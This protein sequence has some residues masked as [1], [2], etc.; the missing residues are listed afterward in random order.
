[1]KRFSR[2]VVL[3]FLMTGLLMPM[4][5]AFADSPNILGEHTLLFG[6]TLYCIGRAYG[7][8][9]WAIAT[10]N[11]IAV[12]DANMVKSGVK[13]QIPDVPA[14]IPAGPTCARQF[15]DASPPQ[16]TDCTCQT[17]HMIVTGDTLTKISAQ[18]SANMWEIA[19]CNNILNMNY[20][21]IADVLCI[22]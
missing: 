17:T 3:A 21:R 20:I 11:G 18:Y 2:I 16:D 5:S 19:R 10:H 22:P 14:T 6:E 8:D 4:R 15:S 12:A 7:V 9:P 1:M 13:L